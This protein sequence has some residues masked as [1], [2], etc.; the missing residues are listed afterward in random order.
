MNNLTK[1]DTIRSTCT[2]YHNK[3]AALENA[4]WDLEYAVK[5][6]DYE[7]FIKVYKILGNANI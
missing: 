4:K 6:K 3:I 5:V 2:E 7:V 1:L